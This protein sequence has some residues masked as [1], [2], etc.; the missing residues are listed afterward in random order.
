MP[1]RTLSFLVGPPKSDK[2]YAIETRPDKEQLL[3]SLFFF[4]FLFNAVVAVLP[5]VHP[6]SL[7]F[8]VS[9]I[10]PGFAVAIVPKINFSDQRI[11]FEEQTPWIILKLHKI[12]FWYTLETHSLIGQYICNSNHLLLLFMHYFWIN[13][14][15][16][17]FFCIYQM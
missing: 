3:F 4:F 2:F 11:Y 7:T 10:F 6:L 13:K 9:H 15:T 17:C 16:L 12:A 8:V 1:T 14:A 5:I